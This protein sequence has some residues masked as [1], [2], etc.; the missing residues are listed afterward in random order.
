MDLIELRPSYSERLR[1]SYL[2]MNMTES[3]KRQY[4]IE[5]LRFEEEKAEVK[6]Y[7]IEEKLYQEM[8]EKEA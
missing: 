2:I 7:L 8:M 3:E 4:M 5:N 6:R 1:Q